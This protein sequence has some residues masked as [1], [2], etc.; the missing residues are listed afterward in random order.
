MSKAKDFMDRKIKARH[1]IRRI[2][3]RHKKLERARRHDNNEYSWYKGGYGVRRTEEHR[4]YEYYMVPERIKEY[5]VYDFDEFFRTGRDATKTIRKVIPAYKARKLVDVIEKPIFK[6]YKYG[7]RI[8]P[9]RQD[10]ARRFRRTNK[11]DEENYEILKGSK[12][13][14][15]YDIDWILW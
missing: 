10:A 7:P 5:T 6:V 9:Y 1:R 15:Y 8:K 2:E 11:F 3:T 14:R 13:K 4:R 12:Y